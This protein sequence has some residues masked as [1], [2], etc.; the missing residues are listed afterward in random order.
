MNF[1]RAVR[2]ARACRGLSQ[3]ELG[4]AAGLKPSYISMLESGRRENPSA[5]TMDRI[6]RA[7]RMTT[8]VMSALGSTREEL[9]SMTP[10]TQSSLARAVLMALS[11]G[12]LSPPPRPVVVLVE[13]EQP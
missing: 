1:G 6:S 5:L 13:E 3:R 10:V 7:L 4:E 9:D 8:S 12:E 2:V 11:E